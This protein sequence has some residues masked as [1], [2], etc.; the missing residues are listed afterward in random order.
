MA[1]G[2]GFPRE[3]RIRRSSEIRS[4]LRAAER[5]RT[6]SLDLFIG[7]SAS[8]RPRAGFVVPRHGRSIVERNRLKRRLREIV[9]RGWLPTAFE[10]G[11]AVDLLVRARPSAYE[12][13]FGALREELLGGL[14]DR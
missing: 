5:R 14:E 11:E 7:P 3:A 12:E 10:A 2:E 8:G 4:L 13:S 9:R 6:P 1:S